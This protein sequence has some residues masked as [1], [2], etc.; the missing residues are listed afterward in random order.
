MYS[1]FFTKVLKLLLLLNYITS[2]SYYTSY[3]VLFRD[4]YFYYIC[5]LYCKLELISVNKDLNGKSN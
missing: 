4:K 3:D 1:F 2:I 5:V